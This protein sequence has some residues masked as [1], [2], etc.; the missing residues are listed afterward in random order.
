M[1][2]SARNRS[3]FRGSPGRGWPIFVS[4]AIAVCLNCIAQTN[5]PNGLERPLSLPECV[6]LALQRNSTIKKAQSELEAAYGLVIQTRAIAIP[7][8]RTT[9]NY[10][11]TD[12]G[13]VETFPPVNLP[14]DP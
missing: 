13:G 14:F 9:A 11:K 2:P 7:K 6:D 8:I 10:Q 3:F 1:Q 12:P 5:S 4:V